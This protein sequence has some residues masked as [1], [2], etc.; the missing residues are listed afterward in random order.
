MDTELFTT[1]IRLT[2]AHW[3]GW[4]STFD[5]FSAVR[6]SSLLPSCAAATVALVLL[7]AATWLLLQRHHMPRDRHAATGPALATTPTLPVI[8]RTT[9]RT[10]LRA[11]AALDSES[12]GVLEAGQLVLVLEEC[13]PITAGRTRARVGRV[14]EKCDNNDLGWLST[15]TAEGKP[16]LAPLLPAEATAAWRWRGLTLAEHLSTH[17]DAVL[18]FRQAWKIREAELDLA[19]TT[20]AKLRHDAEQLDWL[21]RQ[22]KVATAGATAAHVLRETERQLF[23]HGQEAIGKGREVALIPPST[24]SSLRGWYR[25]SAHVAPGDRVGGGALRDSIDWVQVLNQ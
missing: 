17:D 22:G 10:Q 16:I 11:A 7:G 20:S 6:L 14:S 24:L 23:V 19:P 25:A 12:R 9:V 4:E 2:S 5:D 18:A 8:R 1:L 13:Q 3:H 21:V 15:E